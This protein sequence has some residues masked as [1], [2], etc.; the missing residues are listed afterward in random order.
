PPP[1]PNPPTHNNA[2]HFPPPLR[3]KKNIPSKLFG[4]EKAAEARPGEEREEKNQRQPATKPKKKT[5]TGEEEGKKK[6]WRKSIKNSSRAR[7]PR[8]ASQ[9]EEGGR[10]RG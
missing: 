7:K 4:C 5:K 10:G 8:D 1:K 9:R 2:Q 3:K 6:A